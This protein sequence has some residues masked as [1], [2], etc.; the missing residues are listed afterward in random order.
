MVSGITRAVSRQ[1]PKQQVECLELLAV[2][3]RAGKPSLYLIMSRGK[4]DHFGWTSETP[5]QKMEETG[6]HLWP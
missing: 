3:V 1:N 2:I 4:P 6:L 5:P